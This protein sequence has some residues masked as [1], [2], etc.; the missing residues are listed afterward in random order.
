MRVVP[1]LYPALDRQE[2]VVH[3]PGHLRSLAE[4]GDEQLGWVA[5]AWRERSRSARAEGF[6]YVH[7]LVNEGHEAGASLAH[8][9]SQLVWLR[10]PPP[11]VAAEQ[12]ELVVENVVLERDGVVAFC[13]AAGRGPYE[14]CVA[15]VEPE[16]DG[17]ESDL[18]GPALAVVAE[19]IRRIERL[20]G[21]RP[22]L[23]AWL[24]TGRRWHLE[25]LPR[26]T[27]PAGLELGAGI[28]VNPLPPE[29]AAKGLRTG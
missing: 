27:V 17:F 18:L 12:G 29:Q 22:P 23:N 26:L 28:H 4:L 21:E 20:L 16:D 10:E 11:A 19:A 25:L 14:L 15:P 7:A 1:N 9:H 13:P 5:E 24:H 2:V 8:S 6:P 3:S